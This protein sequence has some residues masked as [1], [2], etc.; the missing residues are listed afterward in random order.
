MKSWSD[1]LREHREEAGAGHTFSYR[2]YPNEA[3]VYFLCEGKP[4][5]LFRHRHSTFLIKE[6]WHAMKLPGV[7][8]Y[9]D[10]CKL[11][12]TLVELINHEK[13]S[14]PTAHTHI[15]RDDD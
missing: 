6:E 15:L 10:Y 7:A 13:V 2:H 5:C 9:A 14:V 11:I 12:E 1:V 3:Y 8:S 4:A